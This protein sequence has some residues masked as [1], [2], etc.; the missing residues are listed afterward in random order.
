MSKLVNLRKLSYIGVNRYPL[1]ASR[2]IS[3]RCEGGFAILIGMPRKKPFASFEDQLQRIEGRGLIIPAEDIVKQFLKRNSYYRFSGYMRYFQKNPS[4]GDED[5]RDG[6][7]WEQIV[8]IYKTDVKLRAHLL[9]GLQLAEIATRTAFAHAE[10]ELHS[11][12]SD[13]ISE[14]AYKLPPNFESR[15]T[16]EL[17]RAELY[18][19]KDPFIHCYRQ[20]R[21]DDDTWLNDV[22]IW[23]AVEVLSFGTL[24]KAVAYRDD[25]NLV[26]TETCQLLGV[27]KEFLTT[28]L[29]SFTFLR[30][31]C[32]HYSRIWNLF[33]Q[34]QPSVASNM[35]TKAKRKVGQYDGNSVMAVIVALDDFLF[36]TGLNN[37][38]L[39]ECVALISKTP[40]YIEGIKQPRHS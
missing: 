25:D 16:D 14:N 1:R 4:G 40:G 5:F 28:Q 11:P 18:R 38:F 31:K 6:V 26:Y 12:Y 24:S 33:V 2:K 39:E 35:K 8:T 3:V 17:I 10:A 7:N 36:K 21:G 19:S 15:P 27:K 34:D 20:D 9:N 37:G 13:Y 23:A 30:N 32:A 29:R 22:P